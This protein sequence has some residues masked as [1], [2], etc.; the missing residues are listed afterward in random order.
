MEHIVDADLR[1]IV[2]VTPLGWRESRFQHPIQPGRIGVLNVGGRVIDSHG[3]PRV[4]YPGD[5]PA[6]RFLASR[7][8]G[9]PGLGR[10]TQNVIEFAQNPGTL[11]VT[12][13]HALLGLS[14][15]PH[16]PAS[17]KVHASFK[18][19]DPIALLDHVPDLQWDRPNILTLANER[20]QRLVRDAAE[21]AVADR[22]Q[23]FS[24][25]PTLLTTDDL[26]A[27]QAQFRDLL[28]LKLRG[29]GLCLVED[30]PPTRQFP[31]ALLKVLYDIRLG[32]T[33]FQMELERD[34]QR[35]VNKYTIDAHLA[36][37]L[38]K[39]G[40]VGAFTYALN[41]RPEVA[42]KMIE[43]AGQQSTET[44]RRIS[45]LVRANLLM[46]PDAAASMQLLH[47]ALQ[48][49]Q[50]PSLWDTLG[51]ATSAPGTAS[52]PPMELHSN[53]GALDLASFG[54]DK[55]GNLGFGAAAPTIG[56]Q[57]VYAQTP[58]GG[59][60]SSSPAI[61]MVTPSQLGTPQPIPASGVT[62]VSTNGANA[63]RALIDAELSYVQIPGVQVEE[64]GMKGDH[65]RLELIVDDT[66]TY[67][68]RIGP[69]FHQN[70]P[71]IDY[72][73]VNGEQRRPSEKPD[74]LP[75]WPTSAHLDALVRLVRGGHFG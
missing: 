54:I 61:G 53:F 28:D 19:L 66:V 18:L 25:N 1:V 35:T 12:I 9:I 56:L 46:S 31:K 55:G 75:P 15:G 5:R 26:E 21:T 20:L 58:L 73:L 70:G 16:D 48:Q 34:R 47:T 36:Q 43:A 7:L 24:G 62:G 67:R 2:G 3:D 39:M 74:L 13:Q 22:V 69:D 30:L 4:F 50:T 10:V 49:T 8:Y 59:G 65:Y 17:V 52:P 38:A 11:S 63:L 71:Y 60:I 6:Y 37:T 57:P 51:Y 45:E 23:S 40:P 29:W 41:H 42:I 27:I 14:E 32:A 68:L 33:A 72:V 64:L 44:A